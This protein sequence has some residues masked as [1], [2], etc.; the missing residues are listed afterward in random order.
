MKRIRKAQ[1]TLNLPT[2]KLEGGLFLPDQLEKAAQGRA[3]AQSEADYG[4]PKGVK[5]KDEYSRAF[6]IACAQWQHFAAQME[7][8]DID[9]TQLTTA[10]I[11][12]L[13][14]D[15]FGYATLQAASAQQVGELRY[16]VSLMAGT[17]PVLVAPHTL[18][19][20]EADACFAVQGGGNRKKAPFQAMQELLNA[21]EALQWGIVSNGKQLRLLRDAA[22]LTRPSFLE[23]DLADL[24]GGQRYAEFANVWR[25]LHA[26]R[27]P[28]PEQGVTVCIWEQWR[29]EGQE[30]GTRVRA[31]LRNGVEQALLTFGAGFLQ[32]P[33]N[34]A[35]RAAL[36]DGALSKDDY[37]QQLLRLIYRLIFVFTVEERGVLHPQDD[38]AEAQVARRAYAEGYALAPLRELCLKRRA[39][40]R[41][42]DQWQAIRIVFRGLAQGEPRLALP[43]LGG[44]FAPEQCPDLD[45]A[46]LDNAHLLT[47]L[48]HLR[49]AVVA[50]GKG[51]SLTPVDYRNMGPEELGSVYESLLELVP[52]IDLPARTFGFV[53]RTE[54]GSTAGNAR[55]LTGSYYT[56]DSLVQELIKSALDPVIEQRLASQPTNPTEALLAIRVIDPAC[57]SGHFLLAAARR[58]AEKLAQLRSLEGGQEGAIQPQDYR[59]AL[60]EVVARC[61]YGVDR[62][63]MAIELARMALWLEGYEEGRPL[64]FLDHHLQVGDALLGLS[65]LTVLEQGIAKDAFKPLSGDDKDVCKELAKANAA[66]LKQIDK[67]L[68]SR[69]MLLGVDNRSGLE[70]LRAIETLPADTPEQVAAKE[71]A[72]RHFLEDSAHSPLAYAADAL[73]GAYLLPKREDTAETVPTSIT[74]HALLTDPERAQTEHAA[75]IAAARDAC[76]Q[77]RVFHWPL[78]FPQVFA[79]GGFDCVLGNPPWEVSQMGEEEFFATRAQRIAELAGDARKQAI[80]AL[81]ETDPRLWDE[82]VKE[83][84][85]IAAANN[86]YRESGRF[87]LTAV[88]KLNTYPLFAE[89]ILQI[90]ADSGRA[91]FIVPTG[92][93]TDDSTKA[94]FSHITQNQRL[95]SLFDLEN[96]ERDKLFRDVDSRMKF[97]L[98]TL[99]AAERAEFVCFATQVSQLADPR[100]RFTLT[101]EEFRLINPNT[102]TC[103]VFRSERDAELTKKLY[104]AAPVLMRD[105]VIAGE[106]KQARVMEPAQNPWGITF[107]QGL[108]NMTSASHLFKN[109]PAPDRL[110]L[111]EA[112]LIHQFDHRWATYTPDGNSRDVTLPEKS[113]PD[114]T[115]TPRYWVEAREVWLRV[116]RLPEGLLKAL[117]DGNAQA[118]V[119]CVTQLL[120]GRYLAEQRRAH[121]GMGIYPAWKAFVAQHSYARAIAPTSLG[122]VGNNS[123]SLQPLNEDYLPA[124]GEA[125]VQP[126]TPGARNATAWYATDPDAE[127]AVLALAAGYAHLPAPTAPLAY[128]PDVLALAERWLQAACPQWL[129][130]WRDITNAT[131]ERT[132]IASVVPLVGVGHT[133]PLFST[134]ANARLAACLLGNLCSLVLDYCARVKV[135]GTHLTYGYLK[136][137]PILPPEHYTEADLDFIVPRVLELTYTAWDLQ[138]WAEELIGG[139]KTEDGDWKLGT[140]DAIRRSPL[141]P[142]PCDP[143]RRAYLR[144]QLDQYYAKLYGLTEEELR[145]ILDPT[146]VMGDDYPSETFRVLKNNELRDFGA[147]RETSVTPLR[148]ASVDGES[149]RDHVQYRTQHLVLEAFKRGFQV[150]DALPVQAEATARQVVDRASLPDGIWARP[151]Q[152][153]GAETGVALA[154]LLK[155]AKA[156]WPVRHV[157]LAAVLVLEPRL[158]TPLLDAQD[159]LD[160][161]RLVGEEA[162]PLPGAVLS[163]IPRANQAWGGAVRFLRSSGYL[164][165]DL[166]A[167]TWA[168]GAELD[169]PAAEWAEGRAQMILVFL[170]ARGQDFDRVIRELPDEIGGWIEAAA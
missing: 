6:Q 67:D 128:E 70:A 138:P 143:D 142:F 55:K 91:G 169:V 63:P 163:F 154:A 165:E 48:Q 127:H 161:Q 166:G 160:W 76:E 107:A 123:A 56:P 101:P 133:M 125:K 86:F 151:Q 49:W 118:T 122:F 14:R 42:D 145:Y 16:P 94:Y 144:G 116:A 80:A 32:H 95:V 38:S 62:N 119:L 113:N 155:A 26:S 147:Y 58:L 72:W 41:H 82:F 97:C 134:T 47:A 130:G 12:E 159:A 136:Q 126:Y 24:L 3:S 34:H 52:A 35:L 9:A 78:A 30:E 129:M 152:N 124:E 117:K 53:G 108:F 149:L 87:P 148:L 158:M 43:A 156:P 25:L 64:G 168:K 79:Q 96:R 102:L 8:A 65:D 13:L 33:A 7:R 153:E 45:V 109:Q 93:A 61:I 98:I 121:P 110:P 140:P 69:Q 57:G 10:F 89:T 28:R 132:V 84:Q 77:A 150:E 104:R 51:S 164:I 39:R 18:G 139:W 2:L 106:G 15:A 40:T 21:S 103:P 88:G 105:A 27:A 120:F 20:D 99:G 4:T 11:H 50:Q 112:K 37:F 54:E 157:R 92:I 146:D 36:N 22:S 68:R 135:G 29:S 44:L 83:S 85:R 19:L 5:L 74:L 131:N 141:I 90:H 1:A 23:V 60:R 115:V 66:G 71:Q 170:Q 59:H 46:S 75:P 162:R 100:R 111:Y 73:V 114:F 81:P 17:L 137:F 167:G 31:G